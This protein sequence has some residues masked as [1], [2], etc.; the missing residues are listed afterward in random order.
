MKRLLIIAVA[1]TMSAFALIAGVASASSPAKVNLRKTSAGMI[2]VN[3]KGFTLYAFSRDAK[4]KDE[5]VSIKGCV[6]VWPALTTSGSPVAGPGVKASLLGTISIKGGQ[7]Q[8]TYA[9]HPLYMFVSDDGPGSTE[10]ID[11]SQSGGTW[12]ALNA[13]GGLVK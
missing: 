5:C 1:A 12:P 13:A 10:Y 6:A 7:K 3:S 4:N 2:L 9:G 11:K 8:V